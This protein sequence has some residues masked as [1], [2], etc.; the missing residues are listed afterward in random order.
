MKQLLVKVERAWF[1]W[2]R[3]RSQRSRLTWQRFNSLLKA[4][5]LPPV[6]VY[7]DLWA[8]PP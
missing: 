1:R 5:P 2:L 3:R 8:D 7:K 4:Y 6:R